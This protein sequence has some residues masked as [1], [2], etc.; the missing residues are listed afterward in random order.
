MK[1]S[2]DEMEGLECKLRKIWNKAEVGEG[3]DDHKLGGEGD[4]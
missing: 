2:D 1:W 3:R 4:Y